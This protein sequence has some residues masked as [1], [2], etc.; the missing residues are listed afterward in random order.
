MEVKG[1]VSTKK[2]TNLSATIVYENNQL[3]FFAKPRWVRFAFGIVGEAFASSKEY[4]RINIDEIEVL[5]T[6]KSSWSNKHIYS[7]ETL[8]D[9][10]EMSFRDENELCMQLKRVLSDKI[11]EI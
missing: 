9:F 1:I 7:I 4:F 11:K 5:Y 6:K 3:I 2:Y 10:C 8:N